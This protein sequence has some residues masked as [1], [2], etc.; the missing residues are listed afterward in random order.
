[1]TDVRRVVLSSETSSTKMG[2]MVPVVGGL[3]QAFLCH[4]RWRR[5]SA[6]ESLDLWSE[7]GQA[8]FWDM[9][10]TDMVTPS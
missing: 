2:R 3:S 6:S 8:E 9:R 1:M 5:R 4:V 10:F 7:A